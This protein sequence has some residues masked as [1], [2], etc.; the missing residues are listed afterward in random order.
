MAHKP[1]AFAINIDPDPWYMTA[2]FWKRFIVFF[3]IA[4]SIAS[5]I[6]S[7]YA[8]LVHPG[9]EKLRA[10]TVTGII[11]NAI[12]VSLSALT[13]LDW[14]QQVTHNAEFARQLCSVTHIH[15]GDQVLVATKK[16]GEEGIRMRGAV[17]VKRESTDL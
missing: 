1:I 13:S 16:D 6:V 10:L 4:L 7:A 12:S 17:G 3:S 11:I 2:R 5:L 15:E 14:K 8:S 9:P